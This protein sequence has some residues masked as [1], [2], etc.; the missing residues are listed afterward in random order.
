MKIIKRTREIVA[1]PLLLITLVLSWLSSKVYGDGYVE[2]V[3]GIALR[4]HRFQKHPG[5]VFDQE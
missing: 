3:S 5:E 2:Y 1:T 4:W